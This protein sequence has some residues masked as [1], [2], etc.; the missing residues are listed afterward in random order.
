MQLILITDARHQDVFL[1]YKTWRKFYLKRGLEWNSSTSIKGL[2]SEFKAISWDLKHER[3]QFK[4][5][6]LIIFVSSFSFP[7]AFYFTLLS[8]SQPS[9]LWL[10]EEIK[11][12]E[13]SFNQLRSLE[14]YITFLIAKKFS[15]CNYISIRSLVS[16]C[17]LSP[18]QRALRV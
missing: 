17:F 3:I 11:I 9:F 13:M 6:I 10:L 8:D 14:F 15:K 12:F 5:I 7:G 16:I 1:L 2:F 4:M 18:I